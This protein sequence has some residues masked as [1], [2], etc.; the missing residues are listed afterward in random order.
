MLTSL[1]LSSQQKQ[2]PSDFDAVSF[3]RYNDLKSRFI[4][5]ALH[6]SEAGAGR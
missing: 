6:P 4:C 3:N 5:I 1:K 2:K